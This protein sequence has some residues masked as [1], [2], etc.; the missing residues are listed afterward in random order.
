[1]FPMGL[2]RIDFDEMRMAVEASAYFLEDEGV[3]LPK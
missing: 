1:M 2:R 3:W